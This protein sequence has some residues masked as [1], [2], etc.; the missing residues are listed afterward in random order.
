MANIFTK[1]IEQLLVNGSEDAHDMDIIHIGK[2]LMFIRYMRECEA[3]HREN[4]DDLGADA[5]SNAITYAE[6]E[7]S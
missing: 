2:H 7:L 4:G 1:T 3:S 6:Q 5:I